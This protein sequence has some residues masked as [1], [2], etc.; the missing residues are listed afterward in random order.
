[1]A[2]VYLLPTGSVATTLGGTDNG[3][4]SIDSGTGVISRA[5]TLS[6]GTTYNVAYLVYDTAT[7]LISGRKD[8]ISATAGSA[9]NANW[10]MAI[11]GAPTDSANN[12]TVI[13]A[14]QQSSAN[15][16]H[17][18]VPIT[19]GTARV[20]TIPVAA[21]TAPG[22]LVYLYASFTDGSF[23]VEQSVDG[24][25][26]TTASVATGRLAAKGL[27]YGLTAQAAGFV[28]VTINSAGGGS[29]SLGLFQRA[30]VGIDDIWLVYGPSFEDISNFPNLWTAN[31]Q[32]AY[33]SADPIVFTEATAGNNTAQI[34]TTTQN[35]IAQHPLATIVFAN[36]GGNSVT[37]Q[38]PYAKTHGNDGFAT[39]PDDLD[40]MMKAITDAG[41]RPFIQD[42]SYRD[43]TNTP[44]VN[45]N[46]NPENGSL[47]FNQ[48]IVWPKWATKFPAQVD[49]DTGVPYVSTYGFMLTNRTTVLASDGIHPVDNT[50]LRNY[51]ISQMGPTVYGGSRPISIYE[52]AV[53][54]A[55]ASNTAVL[56][57][58]AQELVTVLPSSAK[59]TALQNRIN[60]LGGVTLA[61]LGLSSTSVVV[62][63]SFSATVTGKT[64]GSTVTATSSDGT[65]LSVGI[66][67]VPTPNFIV[68]GTFSTAGTPTVTLTE[69]MANAVNTP[70]TSTVTVT[71]SASAP[72]LGTLTLSP[73]TATTGSAFS[74]TISGATSGSAITATS[75]DGT[76]LTVSGST[77]SGTFSAAGSPTVTLT[78]T[79]SGAT[80]S[81]KTSTATI[82]VSAAAPVLGT[83]TLTPATATAGS[84]YSGTIGG[85]TSG[86]AIT[87]TSS[88]GTTL[89][90]SGTTVSGTFT[91][92][93][94]PTISL[95]E[96]LS[97]ATGSPKT[98]TVSVT[99]SAASATAKKAQVHP[100]S[101]NPAN[102]T[103]WNEVNLNT[104]NSVASAVAL[105]SPTGT[106]TGWSIYMFAGPGP[107]ATSFGAP[108]TTKIYPDAI[109]NA[110]YGNINSAMTLRVSGL[111]PA[112]TYTIDQ[113]G[114]RT[115]GSTNRIT[116]YTIN[117]VSV[118]QDNVD[119]G[120]R[121]ATQTGLVPSGAGVLDL[122]CDGVSPSSFWYLNAIT[123]TEI[124]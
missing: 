73:T 38:R 11:T 110:V 72:T 63:G 51:E 55:E 23:T 4:F 118:Q 24:S 65:A 98:T 85:R 86:S 20:L 107:Q 8:T 68:S 111:N 44:Q 89:T 74:S 78:E 115:N 83:L 102:V 96:T 34:A 7:G 104:S 25:N 64:A 21:I 27:A 77:V 82:T 3:L 36:Q 15:K 43:Y 53:V 16:R 121:L 58:K 66:S 48:N 119:N 97:G 41:K 39:F 109:Y 10:R 100:N 40:R 37:D 50:A 19:G 18:S 49:P 22:G 47:P 95:V 6:A 35:T 116:K 2:L 103:G 45:S 69:T 70:K 106:S 113:L 52:Q 91:A 57:A 67:S 88:D 14:V 93:G 75:S 90:V 31:I 26:W 99:V 76:A 114:C 80:G 30:S 12:A 84:A 61:T 60:A 56:R 124:G 122:I 32:G 71:V 42:I 81:P 94:T 62:G 112:K 5:G 108:T 54:N 9:P 101:G 92:A 33:P 46:A 117:G 59:K 29:L 123:I 17:A 105:N 120:N 87:A 1:M 13:S 79:L 28:R